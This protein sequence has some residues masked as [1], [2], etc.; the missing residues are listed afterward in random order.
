[1]SSTEL[2]RGRIGEVVERLDGVPKARGELRE[3]V[4]CGSFRSRSSKP[5][6]QSFGS[7][8]PRSGS[9]PTRPGNCTE[10]ASASVSGATSRGRWSSAASRSR[11]SRLPYRPAAGE[12]RSSA[13]VS[14]G[15]R[16]AAARYFPNGISAAEPTVSASTSNPVF[17]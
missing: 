14:S 3:P 12:P 15:R 4:Q 13:L 7:I 1:M 2:V 5:S 8:R 9:T 16:T 10:V 11:S 6:P 17:E